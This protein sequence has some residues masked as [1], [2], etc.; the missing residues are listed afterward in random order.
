MRMLIWF[1][2]IFIAL[3]QQSSSLET[4]QSEHAYEIYDIAWSPDGNLIAVA[5]NEDI[6]VLDQNLQQ[7]AT[8]QGHSRYVMTVSWNPTGDKLAS[9]G[10]VGDNT[11]LIWDYDTATSSFTLDETI[12]TE[13]SL[14]SLLE[15][16]PDG[17]KLAALLLLDTTLTRN[18]DIIGHVAIWD[19]TTWMLDEPVFRF[20]APVRTMAWSPN[21]TKI[22]FMGHFP[23]NAIYAMDVMNRQASWHV[24]LFVPPIGPP[25][26][27]WSVNN[28]IAYNSLEIGFLD[29]DTGDFIHSYSP[30]IIPEL[31]E[32]SPDGEAMALTTSDGLYI[33]DTTTY[34]TIKTFS[35]AVT[36][37]MIDWNAANNSIVVASRDGQI[38]IFSAQDTVSSAAD[39]HG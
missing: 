39:G 35:T 16:S 8:F 36:I 2:M 23:Y 18:A 25:I 37:S 29:G 21:S 22:A 26:L 30:S 38:E 13:S 7:V 27:D 33:I 31:I 5:T 34:T 14:V 28:E 9:G 1:I 10:S 19:T 24:Q 11:V 17:S 32:W 20:P 3:A 4:S 15:W 6:K 12:V